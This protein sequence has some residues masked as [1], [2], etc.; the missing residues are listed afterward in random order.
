MNSIHSFD[1]QF[2]SKILFI[3]FNFSPGTL[4]VPLPTTTPIVFFLPNGTSTICPIAIL[5]ELSSN[6]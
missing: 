1:K 2:I 5:V 4:P 3:F 6:I